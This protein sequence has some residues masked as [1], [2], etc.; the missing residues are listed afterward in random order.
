MGYC[1]RMDKAEP[2]ATGYGDPTED[3]DD[4]LPVAGSRA[5]PSGRERVLEAAYALFTEHGTR[6]VGVDRVIERAGVAKMTFYRNFATKADLIQSV[7][8]RRGERWTEQLFAEAAR[9][10]DD[11]VS[12]LQVLFDILDE[13]IHRIDFDGCTFITS[14]I[15]AW[16]DDKV[17][18]GAARHHLGQ[19]HERVRLLASRAGLD[20]P[21]RVASAWDVLLRGAIVCAQA[22]DLDAMRTARDLARAY[23]AAEPS[24]AGADVGGALHYCP[25]IRT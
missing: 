12:Q 4:R 8:D 24:P 1:E 6:N 15:E 2:L 18:L 17:I 14:L 13:W 11:A 22:G 20:D 9:R 3:Q 21:A 19:I 10:S 5:R 23:L 25:E 7:L 16:P